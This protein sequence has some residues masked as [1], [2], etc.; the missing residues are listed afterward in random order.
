MDIQPLVE[1][2]KALTEPQEVAPGVS[3]TKGSDRAIRTLLE[4]CETQ[5]RQ[6]AALKDALGTH[7]AWDDTLTQVNKN[8]L[9]EK[10][11]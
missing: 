11:P 2:V 6:I 9:L 5:Q 10:L 3:V 8:C 4:I 1:R 7:I